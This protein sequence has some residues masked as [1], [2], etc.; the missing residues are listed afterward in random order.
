MIIGNF[1]G[2]D[3]IFFE[4]FSNDARAA[5][6]LLGAVFGGLLSLGVAVHVVDA[7]FKGG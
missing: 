2:E 1:A 6:N 7:M 4:L 5:D 3:T